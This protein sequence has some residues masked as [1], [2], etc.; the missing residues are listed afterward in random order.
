MDD[1]PEELRTPSLTSSGMHASAPKCD[2]RESSRANADVSVDADA[3]QIARSPVFATWTA[4]DFVALDD[5]FPGV[6][7][8]GIGHRGALGAERVSGE[9]AE[10]EGECG[11]EHAGNV[12]TKTT[13]ANEEGI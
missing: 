4:N 6:V 8:A 1:R 10:R 9:K 3:T 11:G 13:A 7:G 2:G 5:D 12:S